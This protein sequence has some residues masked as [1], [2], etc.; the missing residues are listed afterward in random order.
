MKLSD[1]FLFGCLILAYSFLIIM[2]L[3]GGFFYPYH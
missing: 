1:L 2:L 3:Q